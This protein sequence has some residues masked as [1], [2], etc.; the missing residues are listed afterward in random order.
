MASSSFM[1][2]SALRYAL[3][4]GV[5]LYACCT[6]VSTNSSASTPPADVAAKR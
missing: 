4:I 3:V 2:L 6:H 1:L 5:S